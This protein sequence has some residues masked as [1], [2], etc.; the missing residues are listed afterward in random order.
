MRP[1]IPAR[2][3]LPTIPPGYIFYTSPSSV[4]VD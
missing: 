1:T 2:A 4:I 3:A